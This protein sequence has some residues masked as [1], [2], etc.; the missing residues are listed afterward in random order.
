MQKKNY[1]ERKEQDKRYFL[2]ISKCIY[3]SKLLNLFLQITEWLD[4]FCS[5]QV[6]FNPCHVWQNSF[7]IRLLTQF[8]LLG[9]GGRGGSNFT[10][11]ARMNLNDRVEPNCELLIQKMTNTNTKTETNI[12]GV[13]LNYD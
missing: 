8:L 9:N 7:N 2:Q 6:V 13:N 1:V 11:S 5:T 10:F 12:A 4:F 3:K